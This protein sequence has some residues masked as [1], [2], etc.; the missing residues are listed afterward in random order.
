MG[1]TSKIEKIERD[2][3]N[4]IKY[5]ITVLE[6]YSSGDYTIERLFNHGMLDAALIALLAVIQQ[7]ASRLKELDSRVELPYSISRDKIGGASIKLSART[8]NVEWTMA[9]KFLLTK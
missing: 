4:P 9:C 7:V 2:I 1:S 6:L 5:R 8:A 3:K